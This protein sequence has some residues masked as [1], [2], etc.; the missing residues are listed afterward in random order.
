MDNKNK[1][2][3]KRKKAF[4]VAFE[5][6]YGIITKTCKEVGITRDTFYHWKKEDPDFAKAIEEQDDK[7]GDFVESEL[8]KKIQEGSERSILFYLKYKG[9]KRGYTDSLDI[10]SGGDKITEIR[11]I[12][13]AKKKDDE[14]GE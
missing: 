12:E 7:T 4:L 8:Y 3:E 2:T 1:T 11:L 14:E 9:R 13:V 10:T 6:N 5:K